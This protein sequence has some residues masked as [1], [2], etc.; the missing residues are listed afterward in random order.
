MHDFLTIHGR[1][2]LLTPG[3]SV[4]WITARAGD[5]LAI[6]FSVVLKYM[7]QRLYLALR[8]FGHEVRLHVWAGASDISSTTAV[9]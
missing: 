2:R 1:H 8:E 4:S 5:I 6:L 3:R 9:P 7:G